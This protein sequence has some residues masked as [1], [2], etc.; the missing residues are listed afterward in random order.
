MHIQKGLF[1]T[2]RKEKKRRK[3]GKPLNLVGEED[4]GAQLFHS[5]RVQAAK[6]FAA[7]KEAAEQAE[8]AE[9]ESRKTKAAENKQKRK[10]EAEEK[11]LQRQVEREVKAQEK[12]D[13]LAAKNTQKKQP[14]LTKKSDTKSL[15]VV[16][17]Y[18]K[19]LNSSMKAVTFATYVEVVGEEEGSEISRTRTRTIN[20]PARFK[21]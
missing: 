9:K 10:A 11:A 15:V 16:L 7:A 4:P 1:D 12:A 18:K 21:K 13:K 17:P 14:K 5:S 8:K 3:R 19:T 20:L 6:A 2:I